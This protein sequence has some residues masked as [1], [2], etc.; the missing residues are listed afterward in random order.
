D[1]QKVINSKD[2]Q[3]GFSKRY[4]LNYEEASK[5]DKDPSILLIL[6]MVP[7]TGFGYTLDMEGHI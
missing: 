1:R 5:R 4:N 2:V 3:M 7:N 6:E